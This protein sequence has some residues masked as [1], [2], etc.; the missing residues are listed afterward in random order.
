IQGLE[1]GSLADQAGLLPG[2]VVIA[3]NG[4]PTKNLLDFYGILN[5]TRIVEFDFLLNRSGEEI[6]IGIIRP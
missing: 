4:N 1:G 2:D 3:V 5:D 6:T